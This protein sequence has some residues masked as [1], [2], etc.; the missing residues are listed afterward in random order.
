MRSF[1]TATVNLCPCPTGCGKLKKTAFFWKGYDRMNLHKKVSTLSKEDLV[2]LVMDL[3]KG[4]ENVKQ[5]VEYKLLTP[6]DEVKASKQLIRKYINAYK[7]QGFISRGNVYAALKGAELVL[8]K[9]REKLVSGEEET[10]VHLGIAILSIVV[11]MLQFADD[12]NGEIGYII[13]ESTTLIRDGSSLVLLSSDHHKQ[14][15]IFQLILKE[16]M[17]KRYDDWSDFRHELLDVC[18]VYSARSSARQM[19]E[20]T[21]DK[22]LTQASTISSWSSSYDQTILKELQ[23]KILERNGELEEANQFINQNLE[24]ENFREMA[25]EKAIENADFS[26]AVKLCEDGENNDIKY[27]GLVKKWKQYRLQVYE[28]QD[29]VEKQKEILLEFVYDNEYDAYGRLKDLYPAEKWKT[30]VEEIFEVLENKSDHLP[31]VY[32]YMAKAENR[33][34][35]LLKYCKESP[36]T[37]TELYPYLTD[38]YPDELNQLFTEYIRR[39]AERATDRKM[40]RNVCRKLKIYQKACGESIFQEMVNELK[41]TY[42]RKPA[43]V[44]E[45]DKIK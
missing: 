17:H 14:D 42:Q 26:F 34:D 7:R 39:E 27:L 25:I 16:A 43:F 31:Y 11:E 4:D 19:L 2:E 30:V 23:F 6:N 10:A 13:N 38:D 44:N 40:Y 36:M 9:G 1:P 18:T 33:G 37:I 12:S 41:Q 21:L 24:F 28:A 32:E 15:S 29:E 22:L 35:K 3:V 20:K 45:L 5:K 8:Q